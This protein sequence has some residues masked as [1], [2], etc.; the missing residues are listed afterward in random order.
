LCV[1]PVELAALSIFEFFAK[2][3]G[4]RLEWHLLKRQAFDLTRNGGVHR[5]MIR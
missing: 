2:R 3:K 5:R 4:S 1:E